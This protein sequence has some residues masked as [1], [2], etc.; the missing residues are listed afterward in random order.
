MEVRV[1]PFLLLYIFI[2]TLPDF[3]SCHLDLLFYCHTFSVSYITN[4]MGISIN[5]IGV[6]I[7]F[8]KDAS[9]SGS[10]QHKTKFYD[11][12]KDFYIKSVLIN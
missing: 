9:R 11:V 3:I 4:Y 1:L 8:S 6:S 10:E 12:T 2:F 5:F 7:L